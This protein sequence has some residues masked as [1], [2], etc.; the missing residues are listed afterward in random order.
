[1]EDGV[2][3]RVRRLAALPRHG[4][5]RGHVPLPPGCALPFCPCPPAPALVQSLQ[6]PKLQQ[7]TFQTLL[8]SLYNRSPWTLAGGV[9][10]LTSCPVSSHWCVRRKL[11]RTSPRMLA[12]RARP[13]RWGR[14]SQPPCMLGGRR[15]RRMRLDAT[16]PRLL[17]R[18][19]A[20]TQS[21]Q[22]PIDARYKS[23]GPQQG[24]VPIP[25]APGHADAP[26][27]P[28]HLDDHIRV[29]ALPG[30]P[31]GG[32]QRGEGLVAARLSLAACAW[33]SA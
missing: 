16:A 18:Q 25:G 22:S 19:C 21:T 1:M 15:G 9:V 23:E 10:V 12:S 26:L 32:R 11:S 29:G 20:P 28:G 4:A 33:R 24:A 27:Q 30:P 7:T 5:R 8:R 17:G 6:L 3:F 14:R 13:K 2:E 31:A